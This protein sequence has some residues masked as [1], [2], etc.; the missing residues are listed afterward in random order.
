MKATGVCS[1]KSPFNRGLKLKQKGPKF[2]P[3][4]QS[5]RLNKAGKMIER[6]KQI[7][8]SMI[9]VSCVGFRAFF[10]LPSSASDSGTRSTLGILLARPTLPIRPLYPLVQSCQVCHPH[11]GSVPFELFAHA[12]V[13]RKVSQQREFG[14]S[15]TVLETGGRLF[16]S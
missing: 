12:R 10:G 13:L 14:K 11:V 2:Y 8:E 5:E 1:K 15:G 4:K 16:F 6:K 3:L 7:A 9:K